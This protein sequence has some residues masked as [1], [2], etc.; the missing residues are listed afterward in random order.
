MKRLP[1]VRQDR[2]A[3]S[4]PGG[5]KKDTVWFQTLAELEGDPAV[6]E[7]RLREFANDQPYE[8]PQG[9]ERRTFMKLAGASLAMAAMAGCR[10]QEENVL[11]FTHQPEDFIPGKAE[12]YAT[13]VPFYGTAMGILAK[14]VDGRPIKLEGNPLH[15]GSLGATSAFVQAMVL[16]LYDP[17]RSKSPRKQGKDVSQQEATELLGELAK[18]LKKSRG[19]GLAILSEDHRSF[20]TAKALEALRKAL[21]DTAF[22]SFEPFG[23]ETQNKGYGLA[24]DEPAIHERVVSYELDKA[25][26]VASFDADLFGTESNPVRNAKLFAK[27]RRIETG[28]MSRLYVAEPCPTVTGSVADHR[29]RIQAKRVGDLLRG[30]AGALSKAGVPVADNLV[31]GA[32]TLSDPEKKWLDGLAKDLAKAGSKSVIAVGV[33]QSVALHALAA[34]LNHALGSIGKAVKLS[35][36]VEEKLEGEDQSIGALVESLKAGKIDTLLILGGNPAFNGPADYKLEEA[37]KQAKTSI[38]LST[39][40]DETSAICTWHIP[41]AHFLESWGDAVADNGTISVIQPLISPLYGGRTD[42]EVLERLAGGLRTGYELVV[43]AWQRVLTDGAFDMRFP[44]VLHD[45][46]YRLPEDPAA[47]AKPVALNAAN[48]SSALAAVAAVGGDFEV[49]FAPDPHAYDGRF[50]NNPWLQEL[51]DP[52]HKGTWMTLAAVSLAT[53]KKLGVVDGDLIDVTVSGQSVTVPV[54]ITL[55]HADDSV[56]LPIGQGR[57]FEGDVCKGVGVDTSKLRRSDGRGFASGAVKKNGG[58]ERL[59]ITQGHF[60]LEDRPLVRK[61][62]VFQHIADPQEPR[63]KVEHPPL[64]NLFRDWHYNGHKWGMT[65]DLTLCTGCTACMIACQAENNIQVV[66]LDGV[67]KNRE[68]HWIRIDRYFEGRDGVA[69][70]LDEAEASTMPLPCQHCENAPCE[71]VC[72]VAATT[73]SPE[74][75]NEMTYNRCIGTKYCGNN[76]PYKVRRFNYFNYSADLTEERKLVLNP[77]VTVRGRG[78]ME[79]CTFCVQRINRAK[80]A[81]KQAKD[82]REGRAIIRAIQTACQQVCPSEAITFGDLNDPGPPKAERDPS[83]LPNVAE[84][85][86]LPRAYHILE[87]LNVR[88]RISYLAKITNPND[89][90]Q[91]VKPKAEGGKGEG[92]KAGA[93]EE[94]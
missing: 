73:H 72:P 26:V 44:E 17:N 41:R 90:L 4:G 6:E 2:S 51:P 65:I 37:I 93:K 71:Q 39:H 87:E 8:P 29:L 28:S 34:A 19:K 27:R 78:V 42:A 85:A 62:T 59:G 20:T 23:R 24:F 10:R 92:H 82:G 40:L 15:D 32:P 5:E 52:I 16:D 80:I 91:T 58:H 69:D 36:L 31:A 47:E 70:G 76:C 30:L 81:A 22:H 11:P 66:G 46:V 7:A 56:T 77:D 13:A 9:V 89:E 45:G 75:I 3:T 55:G 12:Y 43:A 74:G 67:I 84:L 83:A 53:A 60:I 50:A 57:R 25:D 86:A 35:M 94:H 1:I 14:S 48:V 79:K 33:R 54:C 38:H 18:T 68:M 21:P 49:V 64:L 88:P 61:Q 63:E